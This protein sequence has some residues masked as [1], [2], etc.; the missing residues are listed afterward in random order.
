MPVSTT[1]KITRGGL[2]ARNTVLNLMGQGVPLLV[3]VVAIPLLIGGLGTERF[4]VLTL[5]W[6]IIGYFSLFDLGIGRALTH[7]VAD[8]LGQ[9]REEEVPSLAWAALC[10]MGLMGLAGMLLLAAVTPWIV[11][12]GLRIPFVLQEESRQAFYLLALSLPAVI[13]TAGLRGIMEA[14]QRFGLISAVRLFMGVSTFLAPLLVLPFSRSLVPIVAVLA[15]VRIVACAVHAVICFRL[16]SIPPRMGLRLGAV[17]PLLYFGG[18]MTVSNVVSPLMVYLDRFLIGV[19][20]SMAAVAYYVTP[21]EVVIKLLVVPGALVGVLFPAFATSFASDRERTGRLFARAV[22]SLFI[23]LF[24]VALV[25][26]AL[27]PDGLRLWL[28]AEFA[29]NSVGVLRWLAVGVFVNSLAHVPFALIQAAGR[30]DLTGKIHLAMLP[31]Y[32]GLLVWLTTRFGIEGAAIA[33][34]LRV[35]ADAIVLF[36]LARRFLPARSLALSHAAVAAVG[37]SAAF[38]LVLIPTSLP[39]RLSLLLGVLA[40]FGVVSWFRVLDPG[41]RALLKQQSVPAQTAVR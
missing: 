31:P 21:Y 5:A 29:Q 33:W 6:M 8:R 41:D 9:D 2:L 13:G 12:R 20:L 27:A 22:R 39:V 16:V 36:I 24:P 40:V 23:G 11:E 14:Y 1:E 18:W 17:K 28:G 34:T 37:V 32:L 19:L 25:L 3:A 15:G 4:G 30:P 26:V 38:F 35:A 10:L 7:A